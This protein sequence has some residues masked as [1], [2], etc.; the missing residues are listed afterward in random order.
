MSTEAPVI[1]VITP[2]LNCGAYIR[3]CIE[4][5]VNQKYPHFEHIVVDGGSH[6]NT[7]DVLKQFPHIKW[8][9]EKDNGE[10]DALNKALRMVTGDIVAWLN[11][12]DYYVPG[13][14][15]QVVAAMAQKRPIVFGD[16]DY[17]N[18]E[19]VTII[20]Q[21]SAPKADL[22]LMVRWWKNFLHPH[23]PA[24][25]YSKEVIKEIGDFNTL[26]HFAIDHEYQ[27]RAVS[28][29]PYFYI[30]ATFAIARLRDNAKSSCAGADA[31]AVHKRVSLPYVSKLSALD[32]LS[33][34]ADY[35]IQHCLPIPAQLKM[36]MKIRTRLKNS[37][38][39]ISRGSSR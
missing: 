27:L 10:A 1:S 28:R 24:I 14:F 15:E 31:L 4:S 21:Q 38:A 18:D 5:I 8:I 2:C 11:A 16:V 35:S 22:A 29:F 3:D 33:F 30:N 12:D 9:S 32:Q 23:Q 7:V 19:G 36:Q 20:Q 13:V 39:Q 25:F 6:D 34:W 26:L 37:L 17:I